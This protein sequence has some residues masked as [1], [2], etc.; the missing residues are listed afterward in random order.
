[1]IDTPS[2]ATAEAIAIAFSG[3]KPHR[4]QRFDTGIA[5]WVYDVQSE[6]G[7]NI[8]VKIGTQDQHDDITGAIAWTKALRPLGIPLPPVLSSGVLLGFPF[9]IMPRLP[10]SDLGTAY[11]ILTRPQKLGL[12]AEL[13]RV[14]RLV[15]ALPEGHAFG[16]AKRLGCPTHPT[17]K[18]VLHDSI[19]RSRSR[20]LSAALLSPVVINPLLE[21][22]QR[23]EPYFDSIRPTPFLDDTTTKNVL[24]HNGVLSGIIDV[25]WICYGDPLFVIALTRTSLLN[26]GFDT[27]YTDAWAGLWDPTDLQKSAL[28]FYT[29][30]FCADFLGELGHR[31]NGNNPISTALDVDRLQ[32]LLSE[33]VNAV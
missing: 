4:I 24:V 13:F 15:H 9:L 8:V 31:F 32:C 6:N 1:M 3:Q 10:G 23:L 5:H 20:I 7:D 28:S 30:L 14:Q 21:G 16:F 19:D 26:C 29:A 18:H 33:N 17:W 22:L 27:S 11:P 2:E 12:A 25:D